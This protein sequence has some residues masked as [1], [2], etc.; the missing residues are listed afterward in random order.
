LLHKW[1]RGASPVAFDPKGQWLATAGN[2]SSVTLRDLTDYQKTW[3]FYD[4]IFAYRLLAIDPSGKTFVACYGRN[5]VKVFP[6]D[7]GQATAA[8][9]KRIGEL[10]AL[11][12]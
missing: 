9:E 11:R 3:A 1:E 12:S 10:I 4:R 2:D 7:L 8:E 5:D 6:L